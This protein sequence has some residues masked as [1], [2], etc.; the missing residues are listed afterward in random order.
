[1]PSQLT[2]SL[3]SYLN[4]FERQ[5]SGA[6]SSGSG[7]LQTQAMKTAQAAVFGTSSTPIVAPSRASNDASNRHST[8]AMLLQDTQARAAAGTPPPATASVSSPC[9]TFDDVISFFF[10]FDFSFRFLS[11]HFD[12]SGSVGQL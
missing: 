2:D 6:A 10:L 5:G 4:G 9:T 12:D 11:D 1:M 8:A 7:A 3:Q